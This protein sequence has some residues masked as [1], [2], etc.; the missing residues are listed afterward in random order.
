L[1]TSRFESFSDGVFAFAITLLVLGFALPG[2]HYAS[3]H[4]LTSALLRL[5]PNLIAY[6]LS[7]AVIG[8][9][10]QNHHALFRLVDRIDR[11]TVLI[12][13]VLLA[14]TAFIPF[15]TSTLG[16]Y[17]TMR[18]STF[19]YGSA[20]LFCSS[21]N[22]LML[23]HLVRRK[24]FHGDVVDAAIAQTVRGYCGAWITY[25]VAML[26][27]LFVPIASFAAYLAIVFY[28]LIPRGVDA[29]LHA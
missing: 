3:D 9:M 26:L 18:A 19:L 2:T 11:K 27:A 25:A 22:N 5:W 17:P 21:A 1:T 13:L 24:A 6:C 20:L 7:F 23:A 15:A 10:W 12:N 14:G 29:D 8:L 4:A 28:F 16:S